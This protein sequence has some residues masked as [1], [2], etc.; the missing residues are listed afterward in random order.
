MNQ[1]KVLQGFVCKGD[2]GEVALGLAWGEGVL[3]C[4]SVSECRF[5]ILDTG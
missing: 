4:G 3:H 2:T 1:G 5:W